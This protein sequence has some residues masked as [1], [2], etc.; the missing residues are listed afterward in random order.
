MIFKT[1][2]DDTGDKSDLKSSFWVYQISQP[3]DKQGC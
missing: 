2:D 3:L 1:F